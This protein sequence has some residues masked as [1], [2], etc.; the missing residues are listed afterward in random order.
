[1]SSVNP[2]G[3]LKISAMVKK[4]KENE[5]KDLL[6]RLAFA[7]DPVMKRRKWTV[8]NLR[9]FYPKEVGLLGMMFNVYWSPFLTIKICGIYQNILLLFKK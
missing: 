2:Y 1:M 7:C 6:N 5:A 9:E 4:P 3:V 8:K